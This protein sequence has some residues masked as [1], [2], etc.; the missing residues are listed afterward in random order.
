MLPADSMTITIFIELDKTSRI[1]SNYEHT[2]MPN[3]VAFSFG[4]NF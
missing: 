2:K 3:L 4:H 1:G